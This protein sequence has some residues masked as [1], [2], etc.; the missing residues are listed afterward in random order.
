MNGID[1]QIID[2]SEVIDKRACGIDDNYSGEIQEAQDNV[3]FDIT[4]LRVK[5]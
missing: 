2:W 3:L 4:I 1:S 5:S